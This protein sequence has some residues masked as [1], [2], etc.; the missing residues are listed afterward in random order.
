MIAISALQILIL[1]IIHPNWRQGNQQDRTMALKVLI[2]FALIRMSKFMILLLEKQ[3]KRKSR[4][5]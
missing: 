5:F 4:I 2:N 1:S 3:K